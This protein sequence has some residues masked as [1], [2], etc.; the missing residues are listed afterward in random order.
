MSELTNN[1]DVFAGKLAKH[2][3]NEE[4]LVYIASPFFDDKSKEWVSEKE[5]EF[6]TLKI[7]YFSPR[8]DSIDFNKVSTELRSE[9]I[10]SIFKSNVRKLKQCKHIAVNLT[11][12]NGKLDIG[13]L[14]ELGFFV[15]THG[16]IDFD[17]DEYN[18]LL[19]STELRDII[20][21][22]I[23]NLSVINITRKVD[24][25][26]ITK[27]PLIHRIQNSL[28]FINSNFTI[29]NLSTTFGK[30]LE[31]GNRT[32]VLVDDYPIQSFILMGYLY[33]NNIPYHT[34][35]F[36]GYGSNVMIAAS[37]QG[38]IQL[39][40]IYDETTINNKID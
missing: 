34:T 35:S 28:D 1:M 16:Y 15:G 14:W 22:I 29:I 33:A 5:N 13:T 7:P 3:K 11:H 19:C 9:R 24:K 26:L 18:T 12:C 2:L 20:I 10:K 27:V 8:Q 40:G 38:H 32:V 31:V 36:K 30:E 39:P 21:E 25:V 4:P 17:N 37:S 23:S 6:D